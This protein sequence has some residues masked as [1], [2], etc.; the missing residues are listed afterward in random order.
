[1]KKSAYRKKGPRTAVS[2]PK[3]LVVVV[4]GVTV[5]LSGCR[6]RLNPSGEQPAQA[7]QQLNVAI[8]SDV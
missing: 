2:A 3:L 5:L 4:I 6:T 8:T 1:M 7:A